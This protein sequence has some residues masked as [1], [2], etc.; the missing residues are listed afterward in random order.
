[1]R[2]GLLILLIGLCAAATGS[3]AQKSAVEG[4]WEIDLAPMLEQARSMGACARDLQQVR[5]TFS[6]GR[7]SIEGGRIT[8]TIDGFAGKE[9]FQY[10][11]LSTQGSCSSLEIR[12]SNHRYCVVR[13]RLEVHDPRSPL[14]AVY[15]R[16]R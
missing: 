6:G 13:D 12:S 5:E 10:K 9:V 3:H 11:V 14:I 1:M 16:P 8:L 4:H 2:N 15:K 7:M